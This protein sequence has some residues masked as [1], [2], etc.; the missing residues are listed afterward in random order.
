MYEPTPRTLTM[1]DSALMRA[2]LL[3]YSWLT[4]TE[5]K[6]FASKDLTEACN[7]GYTR[8]GDAGGRRQGCRRGLLQ[9][10]GKSCLIRRME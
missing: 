9:I 8:S 7:L 6:A 1:T 10:I 5:I 2:A 4:K 3:A